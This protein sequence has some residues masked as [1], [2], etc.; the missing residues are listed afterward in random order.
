M[1]L[2]LIVL[3]LEQLMNIIM[4]YYLKI[5]IKLIIQIIVSKLV[6]DIIL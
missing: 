4:I 5:I 2:V 1:K 3:N 6:I